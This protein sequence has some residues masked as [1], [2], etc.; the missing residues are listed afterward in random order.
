MAFW[1]GL[2]SQIVRI[3]GAGQLVSTSPFQVLRFVSFVFTKLCF[4]NTFP[5]ALRSMFDL[6]LEAEPLKKAFPSRTWE[7]ETC[8]RTRKLFSAF[9]F[10]A[11]HQTAEE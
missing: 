4:G 5:N 10:Y 1:K 11:S 6:R 3:V 8:Q 7:R 9:K 2:A